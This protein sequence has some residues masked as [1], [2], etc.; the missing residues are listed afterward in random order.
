VRKASRRAVRRAG[1]FKIDF[2]L[3]F[4]FVIRHEWVGLGIASFQR[5][6][7]AS[8]Q[9]NELGILPQMIE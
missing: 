8:F 2:F 4:P 7:I 6:G 9:R 1:G 5:L 3:I